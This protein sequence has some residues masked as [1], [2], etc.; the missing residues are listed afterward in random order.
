MKK[1]DTLYELPEFTDSVFRLI[2]IFDEFY[3]NSDRKVKPSKIVYKFINT[4]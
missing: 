4:L 2:V 3:K 1:L